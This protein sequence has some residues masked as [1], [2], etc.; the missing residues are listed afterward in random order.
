MI[1]NYEEKLADLSQDVIH[2]KRA[3]MDQTATP[4]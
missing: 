3:M 4:F 1:K 2:L